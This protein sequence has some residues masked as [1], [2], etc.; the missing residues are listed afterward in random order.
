VKESSVIVLAGA[1]VVVTGGMAAAA[2]GT[3]PGAAQDTASSVLAKV[4]VTVPG[5]DDH[6]AAHAD[7]RGESTD[8]TVSGGTFH[9]N[10]LS[11]AL[12]AQHA[13]HVKAADEAGDEAGDDPADTTEDPGDSSDDPSDGS[14][15]SDAVPQG[16]GPAV[17]QLARTTTSTGA[18]KGAEI[19]ALASGGKSHAGRQGSHTPSTDASRTQ[20]PDHH[21]SDHSRSAPAGPPSPTPGASDQKRPVTVPNGGAAGTAHGH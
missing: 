18:A 7:S 9:G 11:L 16:K 12:R 1:V 15:G 14:D 2:T 4:G 10:A 13:A 6:A 8:A 19:S 5:P 17:S 20:A 21:A 3:L